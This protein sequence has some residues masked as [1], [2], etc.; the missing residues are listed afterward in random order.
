M[1]PTT[2]VHKTV[3]ERG[4]HKI[5]RR[6]EEEDETRS[7]DARRKNTMKIILRRWQDGGKKRVTVHRTHDVDPMTIFS[8]SLEALELNVKWLSF[9]ES[10]RV[11]TSKIFSFFFRLVVWGV[12]CD[13]LRALGQ[14]VTTPMTPRDR[15]WSRWQEERGCENH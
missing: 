2:Q 6:Q 8:L 14:G 12:K 9:V 10:G 7:Q 3:G 5:T 13:F 4:R 1:K 15:S 11:E